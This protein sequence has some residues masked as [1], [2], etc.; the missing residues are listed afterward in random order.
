MIRSDLNNETDERTN[1]ISNFPFIES[2]HPIYERIIS[3][4]DAG[5]RDHQHIQP[6]GR[7]YFF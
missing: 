3:E 6:G 7:E 4:N 5:F 1:L 2:Q